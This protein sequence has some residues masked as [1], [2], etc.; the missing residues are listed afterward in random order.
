VSQGEVRAPARRGDG[1]ENGSGGSAEDALRKAEEIARTTL[2]EARAQAERIRAVAEADAA[3]IRAEV[4]GETQ[5]FEAELRSMETEISTLSSQLAALEARPAA[6]PA[7]PPRRVTPAPRPSD[8]PERP[9]PRASSDVQSAV[10]AL[11]ELARLLDNYTRPSMSPPEAHAGTFL[12]EPERATRLRPP[13]TPPPPPWPIDVVTVEPMR[14][15]PLI[16]RVEDS[17]EPETAM[18]D[19][20]AP[21]PAAASQGSAEKRVSPIP[22]EAVLPMIAL[23]LLLVVVLAWLG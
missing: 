14:A 3:R 8:Q 2:D 22:L 7:V 4:R 10:P 23:L 6:P 11:G 19:P 15:P 16:A 5:R 18:V 12:D 9:A 13:Q 21:L 20:V 17:L 1:T